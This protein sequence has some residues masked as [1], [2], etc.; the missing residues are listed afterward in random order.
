MDWVKEKLW[1]ISDVF[2]EF[3]RVYW[4][5]IFYMILAVITVFGYVPFFH[6]I[7]SLNFLGVMPFKQM[8]VENWNMLRWGL[9]VSPVVILLVGWIHAADLYERLMRKRYR[10]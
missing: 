7:A 3:P 1:Q 8:I 9:I 2:E 5:S 6:A 4:C 10:Y